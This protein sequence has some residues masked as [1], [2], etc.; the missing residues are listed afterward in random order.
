MAPPQKKKHL[1][2]LE[3]SFPK[4]MQDIRSLLSL[5]DDLEKRLGAVVKSTAPEM[6]EIYLSYVREYV[7][8]IYIY[9]VICFRK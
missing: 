4:V 7:G 6:M 5:T 9:I 3:T 1:S 2:W 8:Y